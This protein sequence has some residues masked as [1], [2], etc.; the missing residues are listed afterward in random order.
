[1][2]G[3][4]QGPRSRRP[5]TR[6]RMMKASSPKVSWNLRPWYPGEGSVKTGNLPLVQSKFP[7]STMMPPMEVPWPPIHLVAEATTMSAPCSMGR[8]R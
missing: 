6:A 3:L 8:Q 2:K 4:R 1:M 5:S 7:P